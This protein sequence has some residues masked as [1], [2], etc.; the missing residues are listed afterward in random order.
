MLP[1]GEPGVIWVRTASTSFEYHNDPEKTANTYRDGGWFSVGDMGYMDA[2]DYI[3]I[4]D[5]KSDMVI[6]GGVNIYPRE[7]ENC[8]YES[9]DV[10]DCAVFGVPDEKWGES[11]VAVVQRRVGSNL[12]AEGVVA[13]VRDHMADY[14]KPR[15]VEFV[16]EL[17]RDPNGKV[18][19]R[20]LRDD[21]VASL[22][23]LS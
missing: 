18:V 7:I 1:R 21:Y 6:S 8:L 23:S 12:D 17:P 5:R 15:Y 13:W 16:D 22:A 20:K 14:K 3:Y 10:V 4:T 9:P 2:D 11:L 19:K